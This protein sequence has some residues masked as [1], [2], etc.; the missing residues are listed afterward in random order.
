MS[1]AH[2]SAF[3]LVAFTLVT[4]LVSRA[5]ALTFVLAFVLASCTS[6]STSKFALL[7]AFSFVSSMKNRPSTQALVQPSR[8][9]SFVARSPNNRRKPFS[10]ADFP[11]PVSPVMT[12]SPLS[13]V[14]ETLCI[15]ARSVIC[16]SS[17]ITSPFI[18]I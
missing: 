6:A 14:S 17:I 9:L 2:A 10:N 15:S 11:L 12:V 8:I 18:T 3:A 13:N 7:A 1:P 5:L 4:V 16:T